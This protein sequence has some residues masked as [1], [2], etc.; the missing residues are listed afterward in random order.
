MA[1]FVLCVGLIYCC[2]WFCLLLYLISFV[3][4]GVKDYTR[5]VFI[6]GKGATLP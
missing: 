2:V 4:R 6:G 3:L 5:E 1:C